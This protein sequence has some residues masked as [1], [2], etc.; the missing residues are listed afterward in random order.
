MHANDANK[1]KYCEMKKTSVN[2]YKSLL[3]SAVLFLLLSHFPFLIS[4]KMVFAANEDVFKAA[5]EA[6]QLRLS[7]DKNSSAYPWCETGKTPGGF[8]A[9]F[10]RIALGLVGG[11]A[12][13]VLIYGAILW[14]LSEAVTSKEYAKKW[15][16]GA[17]WGLVLLL[18]AYLILYTIN[19]D[20]VNIGQTQSF[21][22]K[23]IKRVDIQRLTPSALTGYSREE[24]QTG[25][26]LAL[27]K[28][29]NA[30]LT[31][32]TVRDRLKNL[33]GIGVLGGIDNP[34]PP[35]V[36]K[37]CV[38]FDGMRKAALDEIIQIG[39]DDA[40]G[41]R[42]LIITSV[43]EGNHAAGD[44]SHKNGSK[45]DMVGSAEMDKLIRTTFQQSGFRTDIKDINGQERQLGIFKVDRGS[46][47]AEY[48]FEP[49]ITYKDSAGNT[50]TR[51]AHWDV[52]AV[53]KSN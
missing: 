24:I 28:N 12:L 22:D 50:K 23:L 30:V 31:E 10:Y 20:L 44:Y 33:G 26:D 8:V 36:S 34:C 7:C 13:G 25:I 35:G 9:T 47:I 6:A 45:F 48:V 4:P 32:A 40:G 15:I 2:F 52:Q 18:G 49:A 39:M 41:S 42:G 53:P 27:G 14:T 1:C 17:V 5:E 16:T 46:Y 3:I 51:G 11:A 21:L 37:G 19:P 29:L 38:S 43:T